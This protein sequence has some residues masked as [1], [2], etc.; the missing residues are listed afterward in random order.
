MKRIH[1]ALLAAGVVTVST[2]A[3]IFAMGPVAAQDL[4]P[5]KPPA[6]ATHASPPPQ[7][8]PTPP[9]AAPA[10]EDQGP[11]AADSGEAIP[12][13]TA[14]TEQEQAQP[15][16]LAQPADDPA[17]EAYLKALDGLTDDQAQMVPVV[18]ATIGELVCDGLEVDKKK[19]A[20]F[21]A[22][23][24]ADDTAQA[25]KDAAAVAKSTSDVLLAPWLAHVQKD[26]GPFCEQAYALKDSGRDL[27]K[28]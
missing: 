26:S 1:W 18:L 10:A 2:G 7:K 27:W 5:G 14:G 3:A 20:E 16:E 28:H 4:G 17:R 23:H 12:E 13:S 24:A 25:R 19:S 9:P 6:H 22:S 21:V 11:S 15:T 8:T